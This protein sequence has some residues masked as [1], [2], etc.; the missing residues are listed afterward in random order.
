MIFKPVLIEKI[1]TGEKTVTRRPADVITPCYYKVGQV[2]ALQPGMGRQ[3]VGRIKVTDTMRWKLGAI[4]DADAV[5]EGFPDRA[6]FIHYWRRLYDGKFD[7]NLTVWRIA[8]ELAETTHTIC[9][10]C[11]G[12]GVTPV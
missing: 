12:T 5:R 1:L 2:Y 11:G 6:A 3:T 8:F 10:C 9:K 4:D 7:G